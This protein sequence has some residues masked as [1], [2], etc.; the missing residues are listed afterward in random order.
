MYIHVYC[1]QVKMPISFFGPSAAW[2]FLKSPSAPL[3]HQS[4][5]LTCPEAFVFRLP[6]G[7]VSRFYPK[8]VNENRVVA[9]TSLAFQ[10]FHQPFL[11]ISGCPRLDFEACK[12]SQG[13]C[14][15][16][17]LEVRLSE[18][19]ESARRLGD[20]QRTKTSSTFS[21]RWVYPKVLQDLWP[22]LR[23]NTSAEVTS[24][25]HSN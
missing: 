3:D 4:C 2:R 18:I 10:W 23:H 22:V 15:E 12:A 7:R 14:Q 20:Q 19:P 21:G 6:P 13:I 9:E 17:C 5:S 16:H 11:R 24:P 8:S 1:I 25:W